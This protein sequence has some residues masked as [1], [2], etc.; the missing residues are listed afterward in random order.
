MKFFFY[1][2]VLLLAIASTTV[3]A[4][5]KI[6]IVGGDT[7]DW[8]KVKAKDSPL[9][10]VVRL[11][12]IGNEL[13]KITDVHPGCGCTKTAELDKKELKPGET[14]STEISLNF[15]AA[16]GP[17]TKSVTITS[18]DP[19]NPSTNLILKADVIRDINLIPTSFFT[20]SDMVV[21]KLAT[22]SLTL[23]NNST[24]D[25]TITGVSALNGASLNLKKGTIL[26]KGSKLEVIASIT[27]KVKG[28]YS[29]SCRIETSHPDYSAMEIPAY[30]NI[31]DENESVSIPHNPPSLPIVSS[32]NS[33]TT[34]G[35]GVAV[36]NNSEIPSQALE[37][38]PSSL[39]T[40]TNLSVGKQAKATIT[41]HN[42]SKRDVILDNV[43][44]SNGLTV[45]IKKGTVIK[46]GAKKVVIGSITPTVKG[47]INAIAQVHAANNA[48]NLLLVAV[49][50][51]K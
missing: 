50:E 23:Q 27:P 32:D 30:G 14:A 1:I 6:Q 8:G 16:S 12:N 47:K 28:Y 49:G 41:L 33:G 19:T 26:K 31:R 2:S 46:R 13:L 44:T 11:K 22:A 20:F 39:F 25:I 4:Q 38:K 35:T 45:N 48:A 21:G 51:V 40:F 3:T 36:Y 5:P 29:T 10:T 18:N 9:K 24:E 37:V 17:L 42:T 34:S 15:G 43:T 7:H